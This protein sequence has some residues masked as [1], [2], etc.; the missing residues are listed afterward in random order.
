MRRSLLP[1]PVAA[2]AVAH[3]FVG[4]REIG[5]DNRGPG[6]EWILRAAG[7]SPGAPWCAAYVNR[8]VEVACA[9]HN[10]VSPLESVPLQGYVQ[11][12]YEHGVENGWL[13]PFTRVIPGDLF[14]VYSQT[15]GRY[16]HI[17]FVDRLVNGTIHTVE[18]NTNDDGSREGYGV[19]TRER[20]LSE[21][22]IFL[23]WTGGLT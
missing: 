1:L 4:L 10:V 18:G 13:A 16:A 3:D 12:Y 11:S 17:G 22:I 19:F 6:V 2:L 20:P 9:I 5:G 23:H 15:K 14:L 21:R 8:A 7:L